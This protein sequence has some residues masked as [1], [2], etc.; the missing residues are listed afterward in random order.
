LRDWT[1]DEIQRA[2][3]ETPQ[4]RKLREELGMNDLYEK[5]D[6]QLEQN[7]KLVAKIEELEERN[8]KLEERQNKDSVEIMELAEENDRLKTIIVKL[9]ERFLV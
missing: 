4:I 9:T 3:L 2:V 1:F 8:A 5:Y 7:E 6:R